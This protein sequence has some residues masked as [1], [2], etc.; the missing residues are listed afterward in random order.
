MKS[1]RE[2]SR[3]LEAGWQNYWRD[4]GIYRTPNPG[5]QDFVAGRPKALILDMFPYPSGIGLH[6]GHPLGFIATDVYARFKR[7]RGFNVLHSMGF[8]AFGLP[9]E[10]YAIQTGQHPRV[11]TESNIANMLA[12]LGRLGLDHDPDRR[13][14][15]TDPAY[16]KWT[17]WI[18][19]QLFHSY[20][21]PTVTWRDHAGRNFMGHARPV[22]ELRAKLR[23]GEWR[24]DVSGTPVPAGDAGATEH[25]QLGEEE[26]EQAIDRARLAY[27]ADVPVNWCPMLGTVLSNEEVTRDGRSER[28]D[29]PVYRR[30]LK[31]WMLRI[32][33]YAERLVQDLDLVEWP[34]GIVDM[35]KNWIGASDGAELMFPVEGAEGAPTSLRVFTTRPD[36]I[37][38]VTFIALA[39][40]SPAVMTL[41]APERREAV[42]A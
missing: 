16:Y 37:F 22:T 23:S 1:Y 32:T 26:I 15:T 24:V 36:T 14:A 38:G 33:A 42:D 25:W 8:D 2:V 12:Q 18:F 11:T 35:Q 21:D 6:I 10:Q 34:R 29:F 5:D 27:L 31:Q 20:Y 28:G 41:T 13:F 30:T 9:A 19:L 17:Q 40:E 7:M 39:P 4:R 3:E